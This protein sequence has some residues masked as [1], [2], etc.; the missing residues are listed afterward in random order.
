M[1]TM[2][3]GGN[4]K[5]I[6]KIR[7]FNQHAVYT[8]SAISRQAYSNIENGKS[9]PKTST[10]IKIAHVLDAD[11]KDF[12]V[13]PVEFHSIRFR[14][15][16][17]N[18]QKDKMK[19]E[20]ILMNLSFWLKNYNYLEEITN[21]KQVYCLRNFNNLIPI[22]LAK[23]VREKLKL[24]NDEP[25]YDICN[26]VNE[27][28]IKIFRFEC[29]LDKCFGFSV[30]EDDEG[31]VI[32]VNTYKNISIE[33]QIFTIAHELGHLLMHKNSYKPELIEEKVNEEKE[34]DQFAA[35]FLMPAEGFKKELKKVSGLHWI[36]QIL[37]IKRI[38]KV[39]YKTV[40]RRLI[41]LNL[42]SNNIYMYF[43]AEFKRKYHKDLKKHFEPYSVE[44]EG[45]LKS[46]FVN[47]RLN[48]LVRIAYE[49]ELITLN[50]ASEILS[51]PLI[52]MKELTSSWNEIKYATN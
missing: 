4:I 39:S 36:G 34:A 27:L 35:H 10:L 49:K 41:D 7:G 21:G 20:E 17:I 45:M 24:D 50:R 23:K 5:R 14:T 43:S 38:Y 22:E 3:L 51:L 37:H 9:E 29:D 48:K 52:E 11:I 32:A 12:F 16:K 19:K 42:V 15:N 8:A 26:L 13:E 40:L 47:K 25:I 33:R 18:T 28:G 6:R 30:S 46:D 31:P 1:N 44:P 2:L